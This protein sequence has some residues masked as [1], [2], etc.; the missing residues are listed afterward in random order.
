MMGG[1]RSDPRPMLAIF[2]AAVLIA[3]WRL[4]SSIRFD[5]LL[6]SA[7]SLAPFA[8]GAIAIASAL[9]TQRFFATRRTLAIARVR[10]R[11]SPPTSST[12]KP[13]AVLRFAA[14]L[15]AT[16]RSVARL[17]RPPRQRAAGPARPR[18]RAAGSST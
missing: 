12:P 4:I 5:Q 8:L 16:E 1:D 7:L 14:Q 9:A 15:A 18:R 13:D 6:A 17:A 11:S 2:A 3:L 10:R